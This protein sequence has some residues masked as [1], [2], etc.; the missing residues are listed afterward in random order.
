LGLRDHQVG[1]FAVQSL[2]T[3]VIF[4]LP[5]FLE[6]KRLDGRL[7]VSLHIEFSS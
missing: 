1:F 7:W 4:S 6:L 5:R 2:V 3:H